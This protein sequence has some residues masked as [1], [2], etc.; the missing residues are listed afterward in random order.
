[1]REKMKLSI[2]IPCYNEKDSIESVVEAVLEGVAALADVQERE[3]I[4]VDDRSTDG[5]GDI[6]RERILPKVEKVIFQPLNRGKGAALRT[7]F[8][9]ATGDIVLIQDADLEY[10]PQEYPRLLAPIL[11]NNADVVYGSRFSG[12]EAHRVLYFW[13]M[14]GNKFLTLVSNMFTNINLTDME[15]GYKVFRK[16]VLDSMT[17]EEDRFGIEP[18]IT[19]KIARMKYRIYEVGITYYGRTYAEGKKIGWKDGV[20]A[21]YAIL[22]YNLFR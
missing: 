21:I 8:A 22:K 10:D 14:I 3:I 16:E 4:V 7:G 13:H 2:V 17:L 9:H 18:E 6:L 20:R 19:A 5:T 11:Q 15:T 1:M 12:G